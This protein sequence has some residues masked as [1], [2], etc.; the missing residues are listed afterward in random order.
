MTRTRENIPTHGARA[1]FTV[2][3]LIVVLWIVALLIGLILGVGPRV[4]DAQRA[5]ATRNVL[6]TFDRMLDVHLADNNNVPP[7][8]NPFDYRHVPGRYVV[9]TAGVENQPE[10]NNSVDAGNPHVRH[11]DAAIFLAQVRGYE[12]V[13]PIASGIPERLVVRTNVPENNPFWRPTGATQDEIAAFGPATV[14]DTWGALR[15]D[16]S[17]GWP[18]YERTFIHYVHPNNELAQRLYG[19][20][21]NNR[22]YFFSAGPDRLYGVT[23]QLNRAAPGS[24]NGALADDALRALADNIYSYQPDLPD[25]SA[26]FGSN[27]R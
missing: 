5:A 14:L 24:R 7:P 20:C 3:E 25:R 19:R 17:T 11:P 21:V 4:L 2:L 6:L 18:V 13:A 8:Y 9:G 1:A 22:P 15:G 12:D 10:S 26:N 23:N 16:W 27:V